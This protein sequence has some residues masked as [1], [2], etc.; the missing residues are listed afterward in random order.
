MK[1]WYF[2]LLLNVE[3]STENVHISEIALYINNICTP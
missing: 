3:I 1:H 2:S